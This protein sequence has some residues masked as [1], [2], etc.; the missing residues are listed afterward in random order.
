MNAWMNPAATPDSSGLSTSGRSFRRQTEISGTINPSK[1]WV[2]L[3]ENDKTINDGW[4]VV[5]SPSFLQIPPDGTGPNYNMWVDCAGSYHNKACGMAYAD[6]HAEIKKWRD[7]Y[8]TGPSPSL[9]MAADPAPAN[10]YD[11]YGEL[12]WMQEHTTVYPK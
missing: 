2:V 11:S 12:H 5:S 1:C 9:F 3:D 10:G 6:G 7:K 8:I 4:F